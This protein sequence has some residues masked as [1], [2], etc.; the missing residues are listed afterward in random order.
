VLPRP[1]TAVVYELTPYGRELEPILHAL[2]GWGLKSLHEPRPG[3]IINADSLALA[4]HGAFQPAA[5]KR[6]P[7]RYELHV[8]DTIVHAYVARGAL[9]VGFGPTQNPELTLETDLTIRALLAGEVLPQ[10][11]VREGQLR[12][13]GKRSLLKPF[14]EVFQLPSYSIP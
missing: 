4:L 8:Q 2:G 3:D 14:F 12:L 1:A 11:A 7:G 5:A 10:V 6:N 13:A 9:Q